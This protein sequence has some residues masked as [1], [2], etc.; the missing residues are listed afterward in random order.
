LLTAIIFLRGEFG[1]RDNNQSLNEKSRSLQRAKRRKTNI[2]LN[3]LIVIVLLLIVFVTVNIFFSD[4]KT[5]SK[6]NDKAGIENKVVEE[7]SETASALSEKNEEEE[8]IQKDS[9]DKEITSDEKDKDKDKE[10]NGQDD[11]K[12]QEVVTEGGN[13][14]K[15]K[16]TVVNPAWAPV[17]TSQTGQHFNVYSGVD[18]DEMVQAISYGTGIDPSNMTVLFLGNNGPDKSVGTIKQ[19]D[20]QQEYRVYIEWVDEQG[21][22]PTRVEELN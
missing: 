18:W 16:K 14:P 21:W 6:E 2:V 11:I 10:E 17:G 15:V 19:K 22:K 12:D 9:K 13:D 3:S 5:A 4:D 8:A 1:L 7:N 20:T